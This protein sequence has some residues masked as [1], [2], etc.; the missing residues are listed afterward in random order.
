MS[1]GCSFVPR[2]RDARCCSE[3]CS[4]RASSKRFYEKRR[5]ALPGFEPR[6]CARCT[7]VF[8]PVRDCQRHCRDGCP[9]RKPCAGCG[10][11][12]EPGQGSRAVCDA[13]RPE[14]RSGRP[15]P[16]RCVTRGGP[17]CQVRR[18]P[19]PRLFV[20][21]ACASCGEPF[22]VVAGK[23]DRY[24]SPICGKRAGRRLRHDRRRAGAGERIYRARVFARDGWTCRLCGDPVD[25]LAVVPDPLAA[26]LD[27]ILPLALG[28]AHA[29]ANVQTAHFICNSLKG[30]TVC[31]LAFAA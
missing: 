1:C 21:G 23:G 25:R 14:K 17:A 13:C 12:F 31:Q 30:A 3:V 29:Y 22:V 24:C 10:L 5:A 9:R 11:L 26:T 7:G 27:H 16:R 6:V 4:H 20:A 18:R 2:R 28:G 8:V 15:R 19:K